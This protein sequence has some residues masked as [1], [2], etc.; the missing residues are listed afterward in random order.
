MR[1]L[2]VTILVG[3]ALAFFYLSQSTSIAARGYQID[4]L[5]AVLADRVADQ[6]QLVLEIGR[7]R[8]PADVIERGTGGLRLVP[9]E[10]DAITYAD[11]SRTALAP[12]P[13]A[14]PDPAH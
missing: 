2:L 5:E 11:A 9:L 13:A 14:A 4:S 7:A 12:A 6:Q 8:T 10:P 1:P 3:A